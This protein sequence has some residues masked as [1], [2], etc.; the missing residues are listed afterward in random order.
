[1]QID[2]RVRNLDVH[3]MVAREIA[4]ANPLSLVAAQEQK[5]KAERPAHD[6]RWKLAR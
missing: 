4:F 6:R 1:M 5:R 3:P 2:G